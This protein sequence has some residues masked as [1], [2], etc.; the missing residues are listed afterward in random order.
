MFCCYRP[1]EVESSGEPFEPSGETVPKPASQRQRKAVIRFGSQED[2]SP[3]KK[4]QKKTNQQKLP[5]KPG[6][7]RGRPS[8]N[9]KKGSM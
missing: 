3:Q 6:R 8:K 4:K 2:A 5:E 9:T 7:G 1:I